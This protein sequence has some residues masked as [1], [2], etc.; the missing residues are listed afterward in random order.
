MRS[1][2]KTLSLIQAF[3]AVPIALLMLGIVALAVAWHDYGVRGGWRLA[4]IGLLLSGLVYPVLA[5]FA[6]RKVR[7]ETDPQPALAWSLLPLPVL[8]FMVLVVLLAQP[9]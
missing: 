4:E 2:A 9:F 5:V 6:Y 3:L 1:F 7:K 8:L